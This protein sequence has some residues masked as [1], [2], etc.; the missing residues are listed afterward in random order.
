MAV[1]ATNNP[2]SFGSGSMYPATAAA[3][4]IHNPLYS[5]CF[6]K[7]WITG[8]GAEGLK[9][10]AVAIMVVNK[11]AMKLAARIKDSQL[12]PECENEV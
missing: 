1:V 12:N 6:A 11:Q 2:N 8:R 10:T 9:A 5:A 7:K 4:M 3:G